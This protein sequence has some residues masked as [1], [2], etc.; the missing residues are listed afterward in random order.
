MFKLSG[1]LAILSYSCPPI[2][3]H[4]IPMTPHINHRL[5]SKHLPD[6]HNSF[7]LVMRVVGHIR[8]TMEEITNAM[9][10]VCLHHREP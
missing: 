10:A 6:F 8:S 9:P 5:D 1:S 2:R 3:P 7:G 4:L